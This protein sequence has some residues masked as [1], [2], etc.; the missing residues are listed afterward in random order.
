M[1]YEQI[2]VL[3][4][5]QIRGSV[6]LGGGGGGQCGMRYISICFSGVLCMPRVSHGVN[7]GR[8]HR[9]LQ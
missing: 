3:G 6:L 5:V 2:I 8:Y 4:D 1:H 7:G 9:A